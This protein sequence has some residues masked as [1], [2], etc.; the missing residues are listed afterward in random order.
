METLEV[1]ILLRWVLP[2][3]R[4]E[5]KT[6]EGY[7]S[8]QHLG[9]GRRLNPGVAKALVVLYC[10]REYTATDHPSCPAP[11]SG[12][13]PGARLG[14]PGASCGQSGGGGP[15]GCCWTGA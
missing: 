6:G 11:D 7:R 1:L 10:G 2:R 8:L 5:E 15:P 14:G 12:C 4:A 3:F 13:H 9:E